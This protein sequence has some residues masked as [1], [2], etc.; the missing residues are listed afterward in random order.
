MINNKYNIMRKII[1]LLILLISISCTTTAD[2][3]V[4]V[5]TPI[6]PKDVEIIL[7]TTA[8]KFDEIVVSYMDFNINDWAYGPRQFDYD[9]NGN[10]EP[11]IISFTDYKYNEIIGNAF[12]NN[13]LP[14][15]LKAQIFVNGEL[16]LNKENIGSEGV[17]A[18]VEFDHTI[19]N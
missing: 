18:T 2:P 19:E 17:Y 6:V 13:D 3:I 12:R 7:T 5:E 16:V 14:Y 1:P 9:N 4:I 10:P 8:P 11:I 15:G